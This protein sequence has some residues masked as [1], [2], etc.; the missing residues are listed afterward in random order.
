MKRLRRRRDPALCEAAAI[1]NLAEVERLLAAGVDPDSADCDGATALILAA[2]NGHVAVA[3]QLLAA[4]ADPD[5]QE[6]SGR[7]ALMTVVSANCELDLGRAHPIFL[8]LVGLLLS[9]GAEIDLVD[10]NEE[11]ALD[12]AR[13]YDLPEMV[14]CLEAAKD[15]LLYPAKGG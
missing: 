8:E 3:G 1:G 11:S 10:E 4:G 14:E 2:F 12:L 5:E 6:A 13:S 7:T 9:A 15:G